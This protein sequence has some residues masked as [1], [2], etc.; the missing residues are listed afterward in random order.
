MMQCVIVAGQLLNSCMAYNE[1]TIATARAIRSPFTEF[2]H[3][4]LL[5]TQVPV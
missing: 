1:Y 5:I 2:M 4:R 3:D